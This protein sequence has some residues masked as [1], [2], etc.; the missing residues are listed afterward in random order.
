MRYFYVAYNFFLEG[1]KQ[2]V[3]YVD[4]DTSGG[5]P[6]KNVLLKIIK[7]RVERQLKVKVVEDGI[8][9]INII[10]LNEQDY[11]DFISEDTKAE[12]D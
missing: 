5:Y 9:I 7:G 4:M 8:I 2:G 12:S 1:G 11:K 6:P 3:G 10:E